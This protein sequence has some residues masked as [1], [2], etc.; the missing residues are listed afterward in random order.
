MNKEQ[1]RVERGV[2]ETYVESGNDNPL[3]VVQKI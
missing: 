2:W 3:R 1:G